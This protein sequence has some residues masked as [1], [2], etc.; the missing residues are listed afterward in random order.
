MH[1]ICPRTVSF[2]EQIVSKDKYPSIFSPQMEA[3]VIIILQIFFATCAVLEIREYSLI[4]P[5]FSDSVTCTLRSIARERKDL[6]DYN[7]CDYLASFV[8]GHDEPNP[9]L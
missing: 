5:R 8:S 9:V 6:M 2:E 3:I 7:V 4:F 1:D